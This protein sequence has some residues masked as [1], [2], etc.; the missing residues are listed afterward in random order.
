VSF[1]VIGVAILAGYGLGKLLGGPGKGA[2]TATAPGARVGYAARGADG[3]PPKVNV[4]DTV[5]S[6]PHGMWGRVNKVNCGADGGL[7][8][9]VG[10]QNGTTVELRGHEVTR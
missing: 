9:V 6:F 3:E 2:A 10:L 8:Y 7:R 5:A 4:G 1:L